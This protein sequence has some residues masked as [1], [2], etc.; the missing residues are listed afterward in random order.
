M[1]KQNLKDFE[2]LRDINY[3]DIIAS[4]N[5]LATIYGNA[6]KLEEAIVLFE[7]NLTDSEGLLG[8][9][10]PDTLISRNNLAGAYRAAGRIEDAEKLFETPSGSEEEQDGTEEDLDEETGD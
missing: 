5:N 8:P 4:R 1:Y 3:T 9:D 6:S 2:G 10:H 7:E